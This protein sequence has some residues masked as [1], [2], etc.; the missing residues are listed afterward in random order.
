MANSLDLLVPE[1]DEVQVRG[2]AWSEHVIWYSCYPLGACDAPRYRID[3]TPGPHHRLRRLLNWLDYAV[4]LGVNGLLLGPIFSSTSHGYDTLD[5]FTIDPRLGDEDDFAALVAG[6]QERGI[7]VMLDGV[8]NHV[9]E[10]YPVLQEALAD[11][12]AGRFADMFHIDWTADPPIRLNFEGSDDLVRLNH[13]SP[14][15]VDL[16]S[17]VMNHW[18]DR[19]IDAWRLDAAYAVPTSFWAQVLPQV[20]ARHPEAL[21]VGEVI[22]SDFVE[23]VT[24]SGVDTVTEYELWKATWSSLQDAN[25]YELDWTLTRHN[26]FL[27]TFLPFTFIGNHDVTRIA[28]RIGPERA[29]LALVI[30]MTLGGQPAIY[31]GDEQGF[32]GIKYERPGGDDEIRQRLPA[33]PNELLPFGQWIYRHHQALIA[34][35]RRYSWLQ[36]ATTVTDQLDNDMID[37]RALGNQGQELAVQLRLGDQVQARIL[38]GQTEIFNYSAAAE[39]TSNSP[40]ES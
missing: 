38:D 8:F 4:E 37:Y 26:E 12:P 29:I 27:D 19:G 18:L 3:D 7:R 14:Q 9:G 39:P 1:V 20:R 28:S 33:N 32:T 24:Q 23:F 2:P 31:Y 21:F 11:G 22:Q 34:L 30:L 15:V 25:F 35:R 6:C 10:Q 13:D 5:Y 16:V 17:R 36:S 40:S